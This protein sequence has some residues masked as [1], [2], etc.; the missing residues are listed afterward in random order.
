MSGVAPTLRIS[1]DRGGDV[2]YLSIRQQP[3][4]KG[5]EDRPGVIWRYD[6]KGLA[7]G[8]T[9]IDYLRYWHRKRDQL[10]D[11]IVEKLHLPPQEAERALD[12][13]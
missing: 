4:A 11:E 3:A 10:V 6:A 9:I 12:V 1:Y 7:I 5:K 8:V 13:S 2:L